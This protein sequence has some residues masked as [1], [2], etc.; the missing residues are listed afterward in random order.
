MKSLP[1]EV[2]ERARLCVTDH[3]H[4][5][6]LGARGETCALL[7]E[8]LG[9]E[10]VQSAEGLALFLG[11]ASTVF[12]IDDVHHDTSLHTGSTVVAA[13]LGAA[14][15]AGADDERLLRAVALGYELAVRLSVAMGERHYH[16]FHSTATCGTV[17]AAL[18]AALMYG[19]N[20]E[21]SG[22]AVGLAATMASGLWEGISKDAIGVKHLHSGFAAERGIRAAK[23]AALGMRGASK[24]L[25]GDKGFIAAMARA[26]SLFPRETPP[27]EEALRNLLLE[28]LGTRWAILRNI[29]K[30]YPFCLGCFEPLECIRGVMAESGKR[31][32]D[33]ARVQVQMYPPVAALV[34]N[35]NPG[36][37]LQA[38]FSAT[39]AVALVLSGKDPENA[40][41]PSEWLRDPEVTR[42][43]PLIDCAPDPTLESRTARV[44]VTWKDGTFSIGEHPLRNL[45]PG[46][47]TAR[48]EQVCHRHIPNHA[49]CLTMRLKDLGNVADTRDLAGLVRQATELQAAYP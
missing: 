6:V 49:E 13:V 38:K 4:A 28:G 32:D 24:A 22:H 37:S 41:M 45:G 36:D 39:F 46:E 34:D 44:R 42:W 31:T 10:H 1:L 19:L 20:E 12:E 33:V 21:Q 11:A 15:D 26:D 29:F 35:R 5:A 9:S 14:L 48:F 7:K 25:E 40:L 8:Y 17:G 3:I 16:Y 27:D 23:L 30:R 2:T 18:A 43:Y 47:V